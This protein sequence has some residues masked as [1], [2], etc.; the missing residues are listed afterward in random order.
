MNV[1]RGLLILGGL[2]ILLTVS[3]VSTSRRSNEPLYWLMTPISTNISENSILRLNANGSEVREFP[4]EIEQYWT[5]VWSPNGQYVAYVSGIFYDLYTMR[6]DGTE[7]THVF[8]CFGPIQSPTCIRGQL[9]P[10]NT[11]PLYHGF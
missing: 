10:T 9:P 11:V 7:L 1:W 8:G 2:C 5:A 6:Y 3:L 4:H